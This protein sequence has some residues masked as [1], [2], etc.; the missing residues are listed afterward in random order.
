MYT[1][2]WSVT[3]TVFDS[4][5]TGRKGGVKSQY[6]QIHAHGTDDA[7]A[8]LLK[9]VQNRAQRIRTWDGKS[10]MV[11]AMPEI[12]TKTPMLN[13]NRMLRLKDRYVGRRILFVRTPDV[14]FVYGYG[15][16]AAKA[17]RA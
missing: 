3:H 16:K 2:T 13:G 9:E 17:L 7:K 15:S 10:I 12:P 4:R 14:A 1:E 5:Q 11:L 8:K 6:F